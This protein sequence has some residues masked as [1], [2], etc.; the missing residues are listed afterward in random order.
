MKTIDKCGHNR[1]NN[2]AKQS[3]DGV[4]C[5][6]VQRAIIDNYKL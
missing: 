6:E 5:K 3:E 4:P 1:I 2:K